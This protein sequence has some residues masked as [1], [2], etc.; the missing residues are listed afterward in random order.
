MDK[1][2]M[3]LG[4]LVGKQIAG[5]R[6]AKKTPIA[7]RFEEIASYYMVAS[8]LPKWDTE[9]YRFAFFS[10]RKLY[11]F[12][13][14]I[15]VANAFSTGAINCEG[16]VCDYIDSF[17]ERGKWGEWSAFEAGK[18]AVPPEWANYTVYYADGTLCQESFAPVPIYLPAV[19]FDGEIKAN[20]NGEFGYAN[21]RLAVE[22]AVGDVLRITLDGVTKDFE[23]IQS[24]SYGYA[25]NQGLDNAYTTENDPDDGDDVL[26]RMDSTGVNFRD[27]VVYTRTT[28]THQL[29]IELISMGQ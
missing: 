23:V 19:L 7:Y 20:A 6:S 11:A 14:P 10:N 2:S 22:F 27:A 12:T 16:I 28:G 4:Y 18:S 3:M 26:I 13:E 24:G 1:A 8:P 15:S 29:K 17:K 5:M 21:I 25:G 9:K